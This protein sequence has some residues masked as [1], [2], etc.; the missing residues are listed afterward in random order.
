MGFGKKDNIVGLDIGSSSIKAA[1]VVDSKRGPTLKNFGIVDIAHGAIEEG[2]INDPESVA[3]S[4]RQLFKSKKGVGP[5]Q[6][7]STY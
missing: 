4:I 3:E 7:N 5:A 6:Q 2:T 1:Q